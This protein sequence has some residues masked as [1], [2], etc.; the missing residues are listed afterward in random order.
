MI[1]MKN[2]ILLFSIIAMILIS[3]DKKS[4][5]DN[6]ILIQKVDYSGCFTSQTKSLKSSQVDLTDSL[7]YTTNSSTL[8]LI[9][10][11]VY[12]CCGLLKDSVIDKDNVISIYLNDKHQNSFACNCICLFTIEYSII[13]YQQKNIDFKVYIKNIGDNNFSLWKETKFINGLD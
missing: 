5:S 2:K 1:V 3:C 9:I 12:P 4:N 10:D 11:K 8:T 13:N 7:Y 6:S